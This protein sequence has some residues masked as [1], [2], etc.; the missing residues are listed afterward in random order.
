MDIRQIDK[1][2][3]Q[4]SAVDGDNIFYDITQPPF[5]L[6]GVF[7]DEEK[8]RFLRMPQAIADQT[9]GGVSDLCNKTTGGRVRF[10]TD[11]PYL[12][13]AVT[14]SYFCRMPHM[15]HVG[16][17]GFA[18]CENVD[19]KERFVASGGPFYNDDR[20]YV[21]RVELPKDGKLRFYTLYMPLY[22]D[23][24]GFAVGLKKGARVGAGF[25]YREL[26]PILYYGSSITQGACAH[27]PDTCYQALISKE[28]NV[29]F[30]NLGFSGNCKA[31]R[32]MMEYLATIECSVFVFDYDHNAPT[33]DY[34]R[35]THYPS[36]ELYRRARPNTPVVFASRPNIPHSVESPE[37]LQIICES[38]R[39]AVASGDQNVYMIDGR[40]FFGEE[41][42]ICTVDG[43]HPTD[44]GFYKMAKLFGE[45]LNAILFK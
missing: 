14:Y 7:Y 22:N 10:S 30:I 15:P 17:S 29:D 6:Y 42:S 25:A 28:N 41:W 21:R 8:K 4:N 39:K 27:R 37:R 26:S 33:P 13:I 20:G 11:S 35:A 16:S 44:L 23:V 1:N 38:Y 36:Y 32:V 24:T 45:T 31:E 43:C 3:L 2:F 40:N 12:N 9:S 5:S 18:L 34:L 19:G